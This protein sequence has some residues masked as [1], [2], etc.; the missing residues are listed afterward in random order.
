MEKEIIVEDGKMIKHYIPVDVIVEYVENCPANIV[1]KI[2]KTLSAI[3]FQ[4]GDVMHFIKHLGEGMVYAREQ[5]SK[6]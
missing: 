1:N 4:N 5:A 3:D 2:N 6:Y